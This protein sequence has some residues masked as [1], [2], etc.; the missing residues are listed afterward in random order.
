MNWKIKLVVEYSVGTW[1]GE[2]K[3]IDQALIKAARHVCL[4]P[5]NSELPYEWAGLNPIGKRL[6]I[7]GQI[8]EGLGPT[9]S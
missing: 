5:E 4:H 3:T 7:G 1:V 8:V 6:F 2:A 9:R